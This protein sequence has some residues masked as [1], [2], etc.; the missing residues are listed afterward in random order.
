MI[1]IYLIALGKIDVK[2]INQK[3]PLDVSRGLTTHPTLTP[4]FPCLFGPVSQV[5]INAV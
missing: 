3:S 4:T 5:F 2:K 1:V